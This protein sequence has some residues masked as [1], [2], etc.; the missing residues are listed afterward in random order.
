MQQ[1]KKKR[2]DKKSER[3]E[4]KFIYKRLISSF[5]DVVCRNL[6]S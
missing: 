4:I 6:F 5:L 2:P 1:G 3:F